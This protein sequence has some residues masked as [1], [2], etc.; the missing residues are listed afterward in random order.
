[1][2]LSPKLVGLHYRHPDFYEVGREKIRE[3][4]GAVKNDHPA[5]FTE[6]AAAELG[7]DALLA[8][9]T[10]ISVFGYQAQ[11]AMFHS[12]GV[13]IADEKIV[14]VDQSL[15]FVRP[16]KAGDRLYADTYVHSI[17]QSFGADIIVTKNIV[18]NQDGEVVQE[19]YTTL[20]GRTGEDGEGGF[21]DGSA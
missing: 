3:Y 21:N 5:F 15:K 2:A 14:Q 19:T 11:L 4:A 1:M 6:K 9:L 16:I 17:R 7:F 18:T 12:N 10:F 20:A 13:A 8:P